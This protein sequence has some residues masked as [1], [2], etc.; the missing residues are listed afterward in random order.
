MAAF[1]GG[2][3]LW[4]VDVVLRRDR[5]TDAEIS[6]IFESLGSALKGRPTLADE[7]PLADLEPTYSYDLEPPEGSIGVS[8]WV[9][10][11]T[12]GEA[13]QVAHDVVVQ[14]CTTVTGRT[15][16]LWDLRLLPR[17]A[18]TPRAEVAEMQA[19]FQARRVVA[20]RE[21]DG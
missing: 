16:E 12:L 9:R 11:D 6:A 20:H 17:T 15:H 21:D 7:A 10:A 4:R 14:A 19:G 1:G 5:S 18:I 3:Q 2:S 13:A 8:C